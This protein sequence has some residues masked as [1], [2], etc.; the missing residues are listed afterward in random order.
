MCVCV[1]GVAWRG[2]AWRGVAWRGVACVCVCVR[3]CVCVCLEI[4]ANTHME[5]NGQG[6]GAWSSFV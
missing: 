3:A 1:C 6:L 2:V 5:S 4:L